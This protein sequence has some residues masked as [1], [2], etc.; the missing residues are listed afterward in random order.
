[1]FGFGLSNMFFLISVL[2]SSLYCL[3][4]NRSFCLDRLLIVKSN[5]PYIYSV[6]FTSCV[7]Y[8]LLTVFSNSKKVVVLPMPV[9]ENQFL[10]V[11]LIEGRFS[12]MVDQR[13]V[14]FLFCLEISF[15][16]Q[17]QEISSVWVLYFEKISSSWKGDI[18]KLTVLQKLMHRKFNSGSE[19]RIPC[20]F[21]ISSFNA[22]K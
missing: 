16:N 12:V 14:F 5:L 18:T 15:V 8:S 17:T 7:S 22:V 2:E 11:T 6:Q 19:L 20:C 1:M 9:E 21:C 4:N 10:I 13:F 3:E